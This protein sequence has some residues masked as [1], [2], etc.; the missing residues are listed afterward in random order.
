MKIDLNCDMGESFGRYRI[1]ADEEMMTVITSANIA[2]GYH[3]GDPL[4]MDK[5]VRLAVE[6]GVGIGA[7]PGFPDLM[8]FGRRNMSLSPEE[9]ENYVLYQIGALAA[10]A[11]AAG[12]KL[13][14][15]KPHGALYNMAAKDLQMAQAIARA[16]ARFDK[17]L[18]LVCPP[19]SEMEKAARELGLRVAREGFADRA[20]NADGS[21]RSRR[22]PGA[23][24]EDPQEA[25]ERVVRMVKEGIVVA[26][27][28]EEIP[29]QVETICVHGDTPAAVEI[30]KAVRKALEAAGIEVVPMGK[31][32]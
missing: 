28:G 14:H 4:V 16:V 10:F 11:R 25:A 7:H 6:Y 20:Y 27:T 29:M 12:T 22:L 2:C 3:A 13:A 9:I 30:A 21:L 1:G 8:G 31:L 24:I 18:I 17:G 32:V 15:V 19:N 5:T 23:L 26:Y